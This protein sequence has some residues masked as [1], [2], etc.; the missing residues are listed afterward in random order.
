M[1]RI[2]EYT[3]IGLSKTGLNDETKYYSLIDRYV[4]YTVQ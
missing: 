2:D 4:D 1:V 3:Q